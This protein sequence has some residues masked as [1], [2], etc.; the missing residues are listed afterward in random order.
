[1]S[2]SSK[3]A[4]NSKDLTLNS[5]ALIKLGEMYL[6][7]ENLEQAIPNYQKALKLDEIV[8]DNKLSAVDWFN[9]ANL[10]A[11]ANASEIMIMASLLK[12]ESLLKDSPGPELDEILKAKEV[13][14]K[15]TGMETSKIEQDLDKLV[16]KAL[17]LQ[18]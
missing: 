8:K 9:Y 4:E 6:A 17:N 13:F 1:M 15:S 14:I 16:E 18:P 7:F 11:K 5:F 12:A 2:T 3:I 10:L